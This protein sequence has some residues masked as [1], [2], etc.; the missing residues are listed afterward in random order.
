MNITGRTGRQVIF[1][2]AYQL[3]L[4]FENTYYIRLLAKYLE[5]CTARRTEL[6]ITEYDGITAEKNQQLYDVFLEKLDT[7]CYGALFA[8]MRS[9]MQKYRSSFI[10]MPLYDQVKLLMEILKAFRCNAQ[11]PD[12][13]LLCGKG[14][15]G[16]L[17]KNKNISQ[18]SAACLIH[19]SVTGLYEVKEDI[20]R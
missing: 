4:S 11:K 2:H 19:Q 18:L 20:L 12:F 5:R 3:A 6:P 1:E 7:S 13:T 9:D 14:T 16:S 15:V 8:A 10:E 17:L